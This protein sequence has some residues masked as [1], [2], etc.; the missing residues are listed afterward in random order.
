MYLAAL[1]RG[2]RCLE[3]DVWDGKNV[4]GLPVLCR[5]KTNIGDV[6]TLDLPVV[7][8]AIRHFLLANPESFPV[9]LNIENHCSFATQEKLAEQLFSILGSIGLI[10]VPDES[11][12][13]DEADLLPSPKSMMGKVLLMGKRPRVIGEGARIV[14]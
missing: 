8:K 4:N 7:L 9:I 12:S 10:V 2:V 3:L 14:K 13:V 6:P 1:Y 11:D 5:Q